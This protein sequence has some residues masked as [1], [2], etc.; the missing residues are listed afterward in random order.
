MGKNLVIIGSDFSENG[1]VTYQDLGT[2]ELF[3]KKAALGNYTWIFSQRSN[4]SGKIKKVRIYPTTNG[5]LK[6]KVFKSDLTLRDSVEI[7]TNQNVNTYQDYDVSLNVEPG[8]YIAYYGPSNGVY[9]PF[10]TSSDTLIYAV[11]GDVSAMNFNTPNYN[12][13]TIQVYIYA[14]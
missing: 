3:D 9:V 7:T 4:V 8:D 12:K 5:L 6:I 11:L 1:I 13:H 10:T 2:Q 14:E